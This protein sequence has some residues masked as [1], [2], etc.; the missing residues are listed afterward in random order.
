MHKTITRWIDR[1]GRKLELAVLKRLMLVI[2][3]V[4]VFVHAGTAHAVD[5]YITADN[6]YSFGFG[7][8]SGPTQL[9]GGI[10]NCSSGEIF[11]CGIPGPETYLNVP[12]AGGNYLYLVA[13]SDKSVTQGILG[14]FVNGSVTTLTGSGAW[15]VYATG[16]NVSPICSSAN[17]PSL[18]TV[19][20]QIALANA[21]S[22]GAASSVGWV[23]VQG[24][25]AGTRGILAVGEA[26]DSTPNQ[27][28]GTPDN[29]FGQVCASIMG[30]APKWMWY[31]PNPAIYPDPFCAS[32][33]V[34]GEFLIFRLSVCAADGTACFDGDPCTQTDTCQSG[35]CVGSGAA[36][37]G[38]TCDDG[39]LCTQVSTC[40]SGTCVAS[41]PAP[42]GTLCSDHNACTQ[43]DACQSGVCTGSAAPNGTGCS[44]GNACTQNDAC[45]SGSCVAGIPVVCTPSDP[46]HDAGTCTPTTGCSNPAKTNGASC[47]DGDACTLSDVCQ[48]G[49]CAGSVAPNGT[50]C[51]DSN[52]CSQTDTC[53]SGTCVGSAFTCCVG[54]PD[55]AR[56][57]VV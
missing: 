18:A 4:G 39:N 44:D 27:N 46:C 11:S 37:N 6:A 50:G 40:Q 38:T 14:K 47:N 5:A 55:G 8:A 22:G 10:E 29:V 56:K 52:P 1:N 41:S 35:V 7:P 3:L 48:S 15:Q 33:A 12:A 26:N 9:Y 30:T 43:S 24:G 20:A 45:Q 54:A 57:S 21:G 36:P 49:A 16:V 2:G 13:Y 25:A 53:Q 17:S 31:N 32:P 42:N 28:C 19:Q 34:P 51:T 23:G